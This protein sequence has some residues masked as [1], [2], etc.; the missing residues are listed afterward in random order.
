[1]YVCLHIDVFHLEMFFR[2]MFPAQSNDPIPVGLKMKDPTKT[3]TNRLGLHSLKLTSPIKRSILG[4][5]VCEK[6]WCNKA[7][8][9]GLM[10]GISIFYLHSLKLIATAP[11]NRQ[12]SKRTGSS[13]DHPFSGAKM[14]SFRDG[15]G[16][17]CFLL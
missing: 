16:K 17:H 11:E 7:I 12:R 5:F 3:Y 10:Y 8:P 9:T 2:P 1:M 6:L 14:V 13:A 15:N 4:H